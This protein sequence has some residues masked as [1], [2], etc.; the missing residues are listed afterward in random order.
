[1]NDYI[2]NPGIK[3]DSSFYLDDLHETTE[4]MILVSGRICEVCKEKIP[5]TLKP[6]FSN[7]TAKKF[8]SVKCRNVSK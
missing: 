6:M 5:N 2:I 7:L 4:P 1:M 8:C 3:R